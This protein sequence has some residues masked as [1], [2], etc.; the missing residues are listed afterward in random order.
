MATKTCTIDG[1]AHWDGFNSPPGWTSD[2]WL[3]ANQ[4]KW[5]YISPNDYRSL[6]RIKIPA[7]T[8]ATTGKKITVTVCFGRNKTTTPKN[9]TFV[10]TFTD[11]GTS[12]GYGDYEI[13]G[14]NLG[15]STID[16]GTTSNLSA[17]TFTFTANIND[18][19]NDEHY[20][21]MW[22][23]AQNG[24]WQAYPSTEGAYSATL[25][26]TNQTSPTSP[27]I[28][29]EKQTI[30]KQN[31]SI[32]VNWTGGEDGVNV[33]ISKYS[34]QLRL[35]SASGTQI[36]ANSN[37]S[38]DLNSL[39]ISW[40]SLTEKPSRGSKIYAT[41]QAI[42]SVN[43]YNGAVNSNQVAVINSLPSAPSVTQSS[44]SLGVSTSIIFNITVGT[45]KD[46][47][48]TLSTYF[49][50]D[51]GSTKKKITTTS[52]EITSSTTEGGGVN[53]GTNTILF[54][55]YDGLEY[56]SPTSK[57][58]TAT[59]APKVKT[60]TTTYTSIEDMSGSSST[61]V[62]DVKIEF[63]MENGVAKTVELYVRSGTST[64]LSGSG[65]QVNASYYSYNESTNTITV[66]ITNID[67]TLIGLGSYF[68]FAFYVSDGTAKSE[69]ITTWSE[70]KRRPYLP[71]LPQYK[72]Y[73]N[74][75]QGDNSSKAKAN[76]YKNKVTINF[77]NSASAAG[78]AKI[79]SISI[80]ASYDEDSKEY[81][82]LYTSGNNSLVL[83]L[84]QVNP[85][86]STNFKFKII[87]AAG[88]SQISDNFL[89]L[90]KSSNL[91]FGGTTI[92]VTN[93]NIRP[94]SGLSDFEIAYPYAQSTGTNE[95]L[96][97]Y[98][99]TIKD[100]DKSFN[101]DTLDT[102]DPNQRIV[103]VTKENLEKLINSFNL[104]N[105][106]IAYDAVITISAVDGFGTVLSLTKTITINFTEPP[107]FISS[108]FKIRHDYYI[109]NT[110]V[111][112]N[113]GEE[114]PEFRQNDWEEDLNVIMF[115]AGEGIVFAFPKAEDPN[116][117]IKEYQVFLYRRD[118]PEDGPEF[119]SSDISFSS[120]PWLTIPYDSLISDP[121]D[122]E[123]LYY[124]YKASQYTKNEYFYFKV[125]AKDKTGN[126]SED[127]V[128]PSC[129]IGCR[130]VA[131]SFSAG[132]VKT[133]RAEDQVVLNFNFT[134]T[135]LGGS[136]TSD[137]WNGDYYETYPNF[138]RKITGYEPQIMFRVEIAAD[139]AFTKD[140]V[141]SS[142]I[143]YKPTS[144]KKLIDFKYSEIGP[145]AFSKNNPKI[146]IRFILDVSYGLNAQNEI[147][148]VSA[149]QIYTSFGSVPT[150]AHRAH[151]VG[152]N[153]V[154]FKDEDIFV[155]EN[156]QQ[157]KYVIF[158]G[159]DPN[160]AGITYEI[161]LNV[162]EGSISGVQIEGETITSYLKI[163]DATIDCGTW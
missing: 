27:V 55:T 24:T 15:E 108:S 63:S 51:G 126:L 140:V 114:V 154:D 85:N 19:N 102:T 8:G 54:Y 97:L 136:A 151:K 160:N 163:K 147:A 73:V 148:T 159:T 28:T 143:T 134:I 99:M 30:I 113:V 41:I 32:I 104:T 23:Y 43:G 76:Y 20:I 40:D 146:F 38:K 111:G 13:K 33:S 131:P 1:R 29:E 44:T 105:K 91:A 86:S 118:L 12:F 45:D 94:N 31:S 115:N 90:I 61:L 132:N 117:D 101:S 46:S 68:Q 39:T 149:S 69:N 152:I 21:Y 124:R 128:C 93:T 16:S 7:I 83:D 150:V 96:Y 71:R 144:E 74:D 50:L 72:D 88:Q 130:T 157:S 103:T 60:V 6:Y 84:S 77:S 95:I 78:Y 79:S 4:D 120:N 145:L 62:S 35:N 37:V 48:Q 52:L 153:T 109:N 26:Y 138:E 158:R 141:S 57:T 112:P 5:G 81:N 64:S 107:H 100:E 98:K 133:N 119:T 161:K 70:T 2:S 17:H 121:N 10:A 18:T 155:V 137:G 82:T 125:Q 135:D 123:H 106:N 127:V 66:S 110:S 58:F 89:T 49:S 156:Y 53:S 80:I 122:K 162:I 116:G 34:L 139:Q 36:Y 92:N 25:T 14:N 47:S 75:S 59:F 129:I 22:V 142:V 11:Q 65:K 67:T 87:D 3:T 9:D 42:G 56:S